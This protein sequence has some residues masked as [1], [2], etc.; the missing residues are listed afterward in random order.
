MFDTEVINSCKSTENCVDENNGK[1]GP[2]YSKKQYN[3]RKKVKISKKF[4][5]DKDAKMTEKL[6]QNIRDDQKENI[7]LKRISDIYPY[8]KVEKIKNSKTNPKM[9]N[10]QIVKNSQPKINT[11]NENFKVLFERKSEIIL[12]PNLIKIN[13]EPLKKN[14]IEFVNTKTSTVKASKDGQ[15]KN[16]KKMI[17]EMIDDRIKVTNEVF[18]SEDSNSI[19]ASSKI[20]EKMFV[21]S[22]S[23]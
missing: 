13:V 4:T 3:P 12:K 7:I 9:K 21:K 22:L 16:W 20:G 17:R 14:D 23:F 6:K 18:N 15:R 10:L 5:G 1:V 2:K 11:K 19:P 8:K